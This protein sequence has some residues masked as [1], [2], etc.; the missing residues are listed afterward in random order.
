MTT[1][2]TSLSPKKGRPRAFDVDIALKSA[3]DV[4]W[5]KGYEGASLS[6]LTEAM[7]INKPSMY[8]AFGNK[9]QLF[10]KTLELYDQRPYNFFPPA[11]EQKTAFEV[12]TSLLIGAARTLADDSHPRG[13]MVVQGALACGESGGSVKQAL[14]EK[15]LGAEEALCERF[16][17]A[18]TEGDL[19]ISADPAALARY[20]NTI[21]QGMAIQATNGASTEQLI[22]VAELS[23]QVFPR[24]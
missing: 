24:T 8:K 1:T 12:A 11:L 23:L 9:E 13:C 2:T 5:Q 22:D 16:I 3:L 6:D 17:Q 19:T 4:F 18:Q 20:L 7:G 10:L 15:R 14:I 21:L